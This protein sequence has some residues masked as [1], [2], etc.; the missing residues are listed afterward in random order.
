M[1]VPLVQ[2][3]RP[4]PGRRVHDALGAHAYMGRARVAVPAAGA[5]G[6]ILAIAAGLARHTADVR[7]TALDTLRRGA[8]LRDAAA[9]LRRGWW[10]VA[11]CVLVIPGAVYVYSAGQVKTYGASVTIQVEDAPTTGAGAPQF[12]GP[13]PTR[14]F[15]GVGDIE[16]GSGR[17]REPSPRA[18]SRVRRAARERRSGHRLA[19]PERYRGQSSRRRQCGERV[20]CCVA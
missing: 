2:R 20:F 6:A 12:S 8:G 16:A 14:T 13:R 3:P 15:A 19:D 18:V 1:A 5:A 4:P 11:A 9:L 17:D 10:L 7:S